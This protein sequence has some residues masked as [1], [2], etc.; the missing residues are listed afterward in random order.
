MDSDT[1]FV[2]GKEQRGKT[3][4]HMLVSQEERRASGFVEQEQ[5]HRC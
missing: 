3:E 1:E 2:R 5:E 4:L